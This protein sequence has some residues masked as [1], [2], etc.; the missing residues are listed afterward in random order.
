MFEDVWTMLRAAL[1]PDCLLVIS[2]EPQVQ[3]RCRE[4]GVACREETAPRSHSD[5]VREATAWA[6]SRGVTSLLAVPI[7]TPAVTAGEI[8]TLA[9]LAR[10]YSVV[11]VPSA[12]GAGTNALLRTPPAAI[13]PRFGPG[14]CALHAEQARVQG[15]SHQVV[16]IPGFAADIDTPEDAERFLI[17]RRPCRTATL[18]Q[19]WIEV[20]RGVAVC[21]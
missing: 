1:A 2:A 19:Q 5:S 15:L 18:L 16:P 3:A 8:G 13:A 7:D 14:S 6:M 21:S 20:R 17:L 4:E 10:T 9:D 11:I 12:D